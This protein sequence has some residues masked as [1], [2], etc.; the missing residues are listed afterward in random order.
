MDSS[1]ITTSPE[2]IDAFVNRNKGASMP[3]KA[4]SSHEAWIIGNF[5]DCI[6]VLQRESQPTFQRLADNGCIFYRTDI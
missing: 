6:R 3:Y 4:S 2:R 1:T 5:E